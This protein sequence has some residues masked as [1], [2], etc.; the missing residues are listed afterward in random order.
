MNEGQGVSQVF[1]P[2]DKKETGRKVSGHIY[3]S[4]QLLQ[5]NQEI[6]TMHAGNAYRLRHTSKG[7]LILTK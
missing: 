5:G 7:K 6:I 1:N 2:D 4:E 3:T